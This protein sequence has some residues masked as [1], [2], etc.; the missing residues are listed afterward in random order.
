MAIISKLI[1]AVQNGVRVSS[2]RFRHLPD[3]MHTITK[4]RS[5]KVV[6]RLG[7]TVTPAELWLSKQTRRL[8]NLSPNTP[9]YLGPNSTANANSVDI[10]IKGTGWMP[11]TDLTVDGSLDK[12]RSPQKAK[13]SPASRLESHIAGGK[14][15]DTIA[16]AH[17]HETLV[18]MCKK[19]GLP[20]DTVHQKVEMATALIVEHW[21]R[22]VA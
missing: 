6:L 17:N 10:Y 14:G 22:L 20:V 16:S 3:E 8:R 2:V 21:K 11:L 7:K 12:R 5:G 18:Q 13:P 15:P 4:T 19:W 9:G 1:K